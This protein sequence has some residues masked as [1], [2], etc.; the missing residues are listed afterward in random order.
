MPCTAYEK[1]AL[2]STRL[3]GFPM[4]CTSRPYC[5]PAHQHPWPIIK[6]TSALAGSCRGTVLSAEASSSPDSRRQPEQL[7][8]A[9]RRPQ[10]PS[11]RR[12]TGDNA[13]EHSS[14][15]PDSPNNRSTRCC[16]LRACIRARTPTRPG[17]RCA[18]VAWPLRFVVHSL[19]HCMRPLVSQAGTRRIAI[20][21]AKEASPAAAATSAQRWT[22]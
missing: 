7:R 16:R 8:R 14:V 12:T 21:G 5:M 20:G 15:D 18:A 10:E 9:S 17:W 11:G 1:A 6:A 4:A 3:C 19:H 13:T 22:E 2:P